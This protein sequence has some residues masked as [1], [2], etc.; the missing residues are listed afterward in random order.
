MV[1][2]GSSV[3]SAWDILLDDGDELRLVCSPVE[4]SL[5]AIFG[6]GTEEVDNTL[7]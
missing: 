3:D 2:P 6:N 7:P 5:S 1:P 4:A